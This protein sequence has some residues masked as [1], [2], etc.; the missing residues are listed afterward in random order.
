M[1]AFPYKNFNRNTS[2]WCHGLLF[3]VVLLVGLLL[4]AG[5]ATPAR[6]AS[7]SAPGR[8]SL[9]G[10]VWQDFCAF[11]CSAGVSLRAG[12][13]VPN[14]AERHLA[15]IKVGLAAGPCG[16]RKPSKFKKTAANGRYKFSGLSAG[17]YCVSVNARQ[18][19][20]AFPIPGRWSR[21]FGVSPSALVA[22]YTVVITGSTSPSNLDFGW[23]YLP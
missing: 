22:R 23:Y 5:A 15:G 21:P 18:S 1:N 13:G 3:M 11:D 17:T 4:V 6:A 9:G 8:H 14:I 7:P 12:N 10:L 19:R 2:F 16:E 20:H